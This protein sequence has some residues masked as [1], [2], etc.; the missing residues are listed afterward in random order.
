MDLA[1]R[2]PDP[3]APAPP[4]P[5][6]G[7]ASERPRPGPRRLG[8]R[9][10]GRRLSRTRRRRARGEAALLRASLP[11]ILALAPEMVALACAG[12]GVDPLGPLAG[13]AWLSGPVPWL[14]GVRSF[15]E[16]L[17]DIAATGRPSLSSADL[18]G[19]IEGRVAAR[20]VP[21]SFAERLLHGATEVVALFMEGVAPEDVIAG[22]AA[23]Y[24]R[25]NPAGGV[26]VYRLPARQALGGRAAGRYP[27]ALR[28][29]EG[30]ARRQKRSAPVAGPDRRARARAAGRRRLSPLHGRRGGSGSPLRGLARGGGRGG[31]D[32]GPR[33]G[34]ARLLLAETSCGS[35]PGAWPRR[36][37]RGPRSEWRRRGRSCSQGGGRSGGSSW[38][39]S[40][41][42]SPRSPRALHRGRSCRTLRSAS[43]CSAGSIGVLTAGWDDPVEMLASAV[44]LLQRAPPRMPPRRRSWSMSSRRRTPRSPRRSAAPWRGCV[45]SRWASTSGPRC[46]R[47][48]R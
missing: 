37:P 28:R 16:A 36:S 9:G 39:T 19:R 40:S 18:R 23:F 3:T 4:A 44:D 26:A 7:G 22:Q 6:P 12:A 45:T 15:A 17:D 2:A 42:R 1:S 43:I 10:E 27:G 41:V 32:R 30:R 8:A 31:A 47:S 21:P 46:S 24:R 14:A 5:A 35:S 13:A 20:L 29:G 34:H 25:P 48:P 38:S 33:G 11:G